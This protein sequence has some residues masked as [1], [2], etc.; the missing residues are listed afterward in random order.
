[1]IQLTDKFAHCIE[2]SETVLKF[3]IIFVF[4]ISFV[5]S[6]YFMTDTENINK[7]N[8]INHKNFK[9]K[10]IQRDDNDIEFFLQT[11]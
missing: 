10:R 2:I 9:E 3:S 5:L 11:N 8:I 7:S 1:M 6:K 4:L